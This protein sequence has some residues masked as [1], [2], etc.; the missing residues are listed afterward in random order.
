MN[1]DELA[2][3]VLVDLEYGMTDVRSADDAVPRKYHSSCNEQTPLLSNPH[4]MCRSL[5]VSGL[6]LTG[7]TGQGFVQK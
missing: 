7:A 2:T 3:L 5:A 6:C 1:A 4:H